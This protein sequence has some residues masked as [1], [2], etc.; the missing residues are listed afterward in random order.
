M[1]GGRAVQQVIDL[2]KARQSRPATPQEDWKAQYEFQKARADKWVAVAERAQQELV[3][4]P[5]PEPDH[6]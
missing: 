5:A 3:D 4:R 1:N 2:V 6:D